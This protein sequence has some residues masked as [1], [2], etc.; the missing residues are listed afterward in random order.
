MSEDS[1]GTA[2]TVADMQKR[3]AGAARKAEAEQAA[4]R[5]KTVKGSH[6]LDRLR[7]R[8]E[9]MGLRIEDKTSFLKIHGPQKGRNVYVAKKGGRVDLSGFTVDHPAIRQISEEQAR[10]KHLGKVRGQVDFDKDDDSVLAAYGAALDVLAEP[11]PAKAE[12]A[13]EASPPAQ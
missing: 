8:A 12:P 11:A 13:A 10:Q 4:R 2:G 7:G 9:Q 1:K 3:L 5:E 6:L